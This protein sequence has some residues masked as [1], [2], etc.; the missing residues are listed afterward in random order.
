MM[1]M[2]LE[3]GCHPTTNVARCTLF[4]TFFRLPTLKI[5]GAGKLL[6]L[7]YLRWIN[8]TNIST[9]FSKNSV[10]GV[11]TDLIFDLILSAVCILGNQA[12]L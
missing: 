5:L 10:E 7:N 1:H 12:T 4:L 9:N 2:K 8:K 11:E 3:Y 6:I